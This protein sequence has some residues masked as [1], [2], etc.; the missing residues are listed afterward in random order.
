MQNLIKVKYVEWIAVFDKTIQNKRKQR[1]RNL[2]HMEKQE[3][4]L[5]L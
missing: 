5:V 2:Q 3:I 4:D 1:K